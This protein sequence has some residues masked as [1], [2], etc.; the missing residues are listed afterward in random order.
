MLLDSAEN[1]S[2]LPTFESPIEKCARCG[3]N[4]RR[5][6]YKKFKRAVQANV[7]YT[8]WGLCPRTK[9]PILMR[10]EEPDYI[11]FID[12]LTKEMKKRERSGKRKK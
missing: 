6:L 4:H 11:E 1:P 5:I 9:E 10:F 12:G 2:M 3:K 7:E 8:H